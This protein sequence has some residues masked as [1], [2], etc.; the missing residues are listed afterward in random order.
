[1][2]RAWRRWAGAAV[3][4]GVVGAALGALHVGAAPP[5][6]STV[7]TSDP[8][9]LPGLRGPVAAPVPGPLGVDWLA[10]HPPP[11]LDVHA[12]A[13]VLVDLDTRE[14]LWARDPHGA[15]P[16]AS[17]TKLLTAMVAADLATSLDQPITVPADATRMESDWTVMGLSPGE[18]VT[19]RDLL[20]GMFLVSGNDAAETLARGLTDRD[21][22][23][24][25]MNEKAAALGMRD[26]R[27]T[28][29]TGIDDPGL[30]ASAYDLAVAAVTIAARYP[31]LLAI[32]GAKDDDVA[33]TDAHKAFSMHTLIK[34]VSVYAGAT[35]LKT[36]Y[37]DDAGYCLVGT[38]TRGDR[39]LGVALLHSDLALTADATSLLDYGFGLPPPEPFDPSAV[40]QL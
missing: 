11:E 18:V 38:A 16:P 5:A 4:L 12:E 9:W 37:T 36:G 3:A 6:A 27:F 21:R 10:R 33:A 29:P 28:N 40:P 25:L 8:A 23:L 22:F 15:R 2:R 7:T 26:S 31:A 35:G 19:V 24:G 32:A 14:V 20:Y 17:L 34:L 30:R 1:M 13:A 39:H